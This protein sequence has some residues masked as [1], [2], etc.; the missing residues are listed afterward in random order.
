MCMANY[1]PHNVCALMWVRKLESIIGT[2][3][4]PGNSVYHQ[5]V[6]IHRNVPCCASSSAVFTPTTASICYTAQLLT[7]RVVF[8]FTVSG[9]HYVHVAISVGSLLLAHNSQQQCMYIYLICCYPMPWN[10]QNAAC[11]SA[12]PP[13]PLL[14]TAGM[15]NNYVSTRMQGQYPWEYP[16]GSPLDIPYSTT[17]L[18]PLLCSNDTTLLHY[19]TYLTCAAFM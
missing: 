11:A 3:F 12:P 10:C 13:V 14:W 15:Y 1:L 5:L 19:Y 17:G 8:I 9:L 6:G 2:V 16:W 7:Y 4:S 18:Q